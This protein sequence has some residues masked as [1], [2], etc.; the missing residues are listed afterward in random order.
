MKSTIKRSMK[1]KIGAIAL[2]VLCLLTALALGVLAENEQYTVT[3]VDDNEII[4]TV[5]VDKGGTLALADG[6]ASVGTFHGW[7]TRDGEFYAKGSSITV[8]SDMTLYIA[9]GGNVSMLDGLLVNVNRGSS[10]IKLTSNITCDS[11][12]NLADKLTYLD[13]NGFTLYLTGT[14]YGFVGGNSGLIISGGTIE[15]SYSGSDKDLGL[16][17]LIQLDPQGSASNLRFVIKEDA[18]VITDQNLIEIK[19]DISSF[20]NSLHLTVKGSLSS[21]RILRS[22]GIKDGLVEFENGSSF[23]TNCEYFFE[24]YGTYKA[25]TLVKLIVNGGTFKLD[26]TSGYAKDQSLFKMIIT[27]GS[28]PLFSKDISSFFKDGN[29]SFKSVTDGY[30]F[31]VCTHLGPVYIE[32]EVESCTDSV[33]VVHKCQYCDTLYEEYLENGIGHTFA[34]SLAQDIINTEEETQAGCYKYTCKRCGEYTV[35][36]FY[37]D[38]S[39]VYVSV[40][41]INSK[42]A[43]TVARV[44]STYLYTFDEENTTKLMSF[45]S[46]LIEAEL[47]VTQEKILSVEIPLGTKEVYGEYKND[48]EIGAFQRVSFLE[49]IVFPVSIEN[50]NK[51]AFSNMAKLK[52][53]KGLEYITGT[54]DT[55]AFAQAENSPLVIDHLTLNAKTIGEY[56]FTNVRMKTLTFGKNVSTISRGAFKLDSHETMLKEIFVVGNNTPKIELVEEVEVEVGRT[57]PEVFNSLVRKSYNSTD[58]QFASLAIFYTDHLYTTTIVE[59]SCK[60]DGSTTKKCQRCDL[61]FVT[62]IVE[63]LPHSYAKE[64]LHKHIKDA[65]GVYPDCPYCEE[66]PSTCRVRGFYTPACQLCGFKNEEDKTYMAYDVNNHVYTN[67]EII[68]FYDGSTDS[69][70]CEKDYYTLGQ[71]V[72]GAIEPD[73]PANRVNHYKESVNGTHTWDTVDTKILVEATCGEAGQEEQHCSICGKTKLVAV[74]PNGRH[75]YGEVEIT[76]PGTCQTKG[77]GVRTCSICGDLR[78]TVVDG[79][80]VVDENKGEELLAPTVDS[81][82]QMRYFCT[83]CQAEVIREIPRLVDT[84]SDSLPA[85]QIVLIV[86]GAVLLAAGIVLTIVFTFV[87]KKNPA[88]GYKYKFNTLK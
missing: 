46:A 54:I 63:K 33:T 43:Y 73:I 20:E 4:S 80:H 34:I 22:F 13:L 86:I 24:D 15:H 9:K 10:Y 76:D 84:S 78:D 41:Y 11:T 48:T 47:K 14:G 16:S 19:S 28:K 25:S 18:S 87:K 49:E 67:K 60:H 74:A 72:C 38:P 52:T 29:Y 55:K 40:G 88:T 53:I 42:G 30:E 70:I 31:D 35:E 23:T 44:P 58:Q 6:T 27:E 83:V 50:I 66:T 39:E 75:S 21:D 61:T 57:A 5:Q 65:N 77:T 56:A 3:Y 17:A 81:K 1:F 26:T 12:L 2:L 85:W 69:Y 64:S 32:P 68:F 45:S 79:A 51:Y 36:Y 82:G 8:D 62:D 71:C 59:V 7:F 37:P